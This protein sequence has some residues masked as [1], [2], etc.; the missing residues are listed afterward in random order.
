MGQAM[1][2]LAFAAGRCFP[3]VTEAQ[4][5][6]H[7]GPDAIHM[8]LPS[9]NQTRPAAFF[10]RDGVLNVDRGYTFR[11][12][13]LVLVDGAP[14][15]VKLCNDAGYWVFV[16]TNQA[17]VARGLYKEHSIAAFHHALAAALGAKGGHIDDFR[18]C[19]HHPDGIVTAYRRVC[20]CRKPAPGMVLDLLHTWPV[21]SG[22][23]FLI[24]DQDSDLAAGRAAGIASH[25][26]VSGRLDELVAEV[27]K[28]T[29]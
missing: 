14:E 1:V 6:A 24:G 29:P 11:V 12:E 25:R 4:Q 21:D 22:R 28:G 7:R 9:S 13:D 17:G 26:F 15:A 5:K 23:S 2:Q 10:D 8:L 16:I 18:Y 3:R 20:N 19:P 27:L